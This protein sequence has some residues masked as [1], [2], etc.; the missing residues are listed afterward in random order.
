M[1][2]ETAAEFATWLDAQPTF[3]ETQAQV[4]GNPTAGQALYAVCATCHGAQGEGVQALGGPKL[5]GLQPWYM[6]RQLQ[7][8]K[9][10]VRG[11]NEGDVFGR[12]MAPMTVGLVD[13]QAIRDVTA[14]IGTL[15]DVPAPVTIDQ[16]S[17]DTANGKDI[18]DR[19][20]AACHLDDAS[21]TW[22]TDAPRLA[23][24]SD[25][26][27]VTQINNFRQGIRGLHREDDYGEQMVQMATAMSEDEV[28]DVAAYLNTL[29]PSANTAQGARTDTAQHIAQRVAEAT[30]DAMR[31]A[32]DAAHSHQ[33]AHSHAHP[34]GTHD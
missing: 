1:V 22:Y 28:A 30:S 8:F 32:A 11:A 33:D 21:G 14:Y 31:D 19:N 34:A 12:T 17:V 18:Y 3:A 13:E 27:F 20:C 25:W 7:Y 5:T 2:V 6:E 29:R 26:Y 9:D 23:S 15:P 4:A 10:G 16:D 24:M